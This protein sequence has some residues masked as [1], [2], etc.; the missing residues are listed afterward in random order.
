MVGLTPYLSGKSYSYEIEF[1]YFTGSNSAKFKPCLLLDLCKTF[2]DSLSKYIPKEKMFRSMSWF[3]SLSRLLC[4][5][6]HPLWSGFLISDKTLS[7]G[8]KLPLHDTLKM[9]TD[10]N[11]TVMN[12]IW[13]VL[14]NAVC[15]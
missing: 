6:S 2:N 14:I 5:H 4:I 9:L 10:I 1:R 15:V 3:I 13:F 8:S 12:S 7:S 11:I